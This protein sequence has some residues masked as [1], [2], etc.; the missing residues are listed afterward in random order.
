MPH[1]F[2]VECGYSENMI[3]NKATI[4]LLIYDK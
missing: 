3:L 4:Y 1:V 2:K